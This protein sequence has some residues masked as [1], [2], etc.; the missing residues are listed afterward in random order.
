MLTVS[1]AVLLVVVGLVNSQDGAGPASPDPQQTTSGPGGDASGSP[2]P[3]ASNAT[4]PGNATDQPSFAQPNQ[5]FFPPGFDGRQS[6][7]QGPAQEGGQQ[8]DTRGPQQAKIP[9]SVPL[10]D[11][12]VTYRVQWKE[13]MDNGAPVTGF[14]VYY[15]K[16][17][18]VEF[19]VVNSV[20]DFADLQN[21][22]K[23]TKYNA[24]VYAKNE[25][26]QSPPLAI[27]FI[28]PTVTNSTDACI[29][30]IVDRS[31]TSILFDFILQDGSQLDL[32][33]FEVKYALADQPFE[34]AASRFLDRWSPYTITG[35]QPSQRYRFRVNT[36]ISGRG[37]SGQTCGPEFLTEMPDV[38]PP[39]TPK[40]ALSNPVF[41]E[42]QWEPPHE[43][44]DVKHY[45]LDYWMDP[46]YGE[47]SSHSYQM[48]EGNKNSYTLTSLQ[49]CQKY[50]VEISPRGKPKGR[51]NGRNNGTG[52]AHAKKAT[53]ASRS[54]DMMKLHF[55]T[56]CAIVTGS[57]ENS[58]FT[59]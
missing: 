43:A 34:H 50:Q 38:G 16:T 45:R 1:V 57:V 55:N 41:F 53:P 52:G 14:D 31:A 5:K 26:G 22:E 2:A 3:D 47:A 51:H 20:A 58:G 15:K 33:G 17:D 24:M 42:L 59:L 23:G 30:E 32:E 35:L 18:E 21:L 4:G 7:G 6:P 49:P 27:T 56:G 44:G 12:L 13:P 9:A 28:T 19:K 36:R 25:H 54:P 29:T 40:P 37:G 48:V 10:K 11:S 46:R 39:L 8:N